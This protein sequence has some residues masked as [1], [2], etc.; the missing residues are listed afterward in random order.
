[1]PILAY[2]EGPHN[3][4]VA[5]GLS[6]LGPVPLMWLIREALGPPMLG[7]SNG[8]NVISQSEDCASS[9]LALM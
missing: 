8:R 4:I 1:M 9:S 2:D 3:T 7:S 6:N 5:L